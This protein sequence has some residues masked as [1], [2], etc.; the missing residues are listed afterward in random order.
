MSESINRIWSH[1]RNDGKIWLTPFVLILAAILSTNVS[2]SKDEDAPTPVAPVNP[3]PGA[4]SAI[5]LTPRSLTLYPGEI[6]TVTATVLPENTTNKTVIWYSTDT[7]VAT[8]ANGVV[9]AVGPG[10]ADIIAECSNVKA[11]CNVLVK[12]MA[13]PE[14]ITLSQTS[15]LMQK[16]AT[17]QL[18]AT[19]LPENAADKTVT[20][21]TSNTGVA[22]VNH[23]KVTAMGVGTATITARSV[24]GLS[25]T[26]DISVQ[27]ITPIGGSEGT[28]EENW[29]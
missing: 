18:I 29:N 3:V 25:A 8:V 11:Q 16:G 6:V 15:A 4:V 21:S 27:E 19:V 12:S 9:Q 5:S 17:L 2:C 13:G 24:N 28:G 10:Y 1:Y 23:G 14:S 26:C 7:G 22:T 20:W